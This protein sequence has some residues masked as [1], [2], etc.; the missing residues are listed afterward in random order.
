MS[1]KNLIPS[2]TMASAQTVQYTAPVD[3]KALIDTFTATNY[4]VSLAYISVHLVPASGS[5]SNDNL[6][7]D[8]KEIAIDEDKP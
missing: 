4:S 1:N 2:T 8:N 5:A 7:I 3:K 6:I